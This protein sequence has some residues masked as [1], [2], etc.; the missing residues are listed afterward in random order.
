[1]QTLFR[2]DT[3][4]GGGMI[5]LRKGC[6]CPAIDDCNLP[7]PQ[8]FDSSGEWIQSR[9][10]FASTMTFLILNVGVDGE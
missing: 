5:P 3:L 2:I 6:F 9:D 10:E 4:G 8:T 1:M 7:Q